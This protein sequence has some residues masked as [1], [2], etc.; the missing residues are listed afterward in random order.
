MN[1]IK[2]ILFWLCIAFLL[3]ACKDSLGYDPNVQVTP[4]VKDTIK[5]PDGNTDTV[6]TKIKIDSL[7]IT[8]KEFYKSNGKDFFFYWNGW[9]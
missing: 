4:I 8:L 2:I 5:P 3:N 7:R 9:N 1:I 6:I